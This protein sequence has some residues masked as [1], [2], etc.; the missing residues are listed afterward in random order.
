MVNGLKIKNDE[1]KVAH[2][3]LKA[4]YSKELAK[5]PSSIASINDACA[6]FLEIIRALIGAIPPL[7]IWKHALTSVIAA[8]VIMLL[9]LQN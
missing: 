7:R 4:S 8:S 2:F 1:L 5:L 6:Y 3:Q 9:R